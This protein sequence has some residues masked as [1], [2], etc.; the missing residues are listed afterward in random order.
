MKYE[1]RLCSRLHYYYLTSVASHSCTTTIS[2]NI[3]H[4]SLS[5]LFKKNSSTKNTTMLIT[6]NNT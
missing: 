1:E 3:I 4:Y 6:I 2:L 5:Y